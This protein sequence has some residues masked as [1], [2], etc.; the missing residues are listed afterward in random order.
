LGAIPFYIFAE[1]AR[2]LQHLHDKIM[3]EAS[4]SLLLPLWRV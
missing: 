3:E 2:N 1:K 4:L